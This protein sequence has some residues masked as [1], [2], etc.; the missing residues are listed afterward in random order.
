VFE[1]DG[2]FL[3]FLRA[4]SQC[5]FMYILDPETLGNSLEFCFLV[6]DMKICMPGCNYL[7]PQMPPF[8]E[9]II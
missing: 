5:T 7:V 4:V 3:S 1:K 6:T 2:E 8:M 9:E